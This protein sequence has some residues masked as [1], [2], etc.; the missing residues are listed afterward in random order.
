MDSLVYLIYRYGTTNYQ[1]NN[2]VSCASATG[3]RRA[4]YGIHSVFCFDKNE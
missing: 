4:S 2:L 1:A 3:A